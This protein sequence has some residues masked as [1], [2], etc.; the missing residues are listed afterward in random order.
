[1]FE[2]IIPRHLNITT[3]MVVERAATLKV[4]SVGTTSSWKI[5]LLF[6]SANLLRHSQVTKRMGFYESPLVILKR[7]MFKKIL[8]STPVFN[9]SVGLS[10]LE[11]PMFLCRSF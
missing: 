4:M 8:L 2:G 5:F 9:S 3:K 1:M 7:K 6:N 11:P 10:G